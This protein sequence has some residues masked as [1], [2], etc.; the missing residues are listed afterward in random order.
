MFTYG[1]SKPWCPIALTLIANHIS[2]AINRYT[3]P[4]GT[5]V[6]G[7]N[8]VTYFFALSMFYVLFTSFLLALTIHYTYMQGK[9]CLDQLACNIHSIGL[10]TNITS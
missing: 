5:R 7:L 2:H 1:C 9:K 3:H 8:T 6:P 4:H 10:F